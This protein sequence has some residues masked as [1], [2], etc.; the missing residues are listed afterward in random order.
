M[1][2][3]IREVRTGGH[4]QR[5][6]QRTAALHDAVATDCAPLFPRGFGVR[7]SSAAMPSVVWQADVA[8]PLDDVWL[9]KF[10]IS[11]MFRTSDFGLRIF[12]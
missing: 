2:S 5:K 11:N 1:R 12:P 9:F 6:R 4:Q 7:L 8:R 10:R 3:G